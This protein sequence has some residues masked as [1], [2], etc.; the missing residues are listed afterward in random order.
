MAWSWSYSSD[1]I[2]AIRDAINRQDRD[3]LE[4]CWAEN[5]AAQPVVGEETGEVDPCSKPDL[6]LTEYNRALAVARTLPVDVLCDAIFDF[7]CNIATCNNG[8]F[9]AWCCPWGCHTVALD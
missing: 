1:G 7:A 3:W 4:I 8:A 9:E 2:E 5:T 6:D